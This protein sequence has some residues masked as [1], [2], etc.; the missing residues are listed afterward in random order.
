MGTTRDAIRNDSGVQLAFV[1]VIEGY[2]WLICDGDTSGAVTAW[3]GSQ[4]SQ[5][6]AGLEVSGGMAQKLE[7]WSNELPAGGMTFTIYGEDFAVDMFKAKPSIRSE[8]TVSFDT[9]NSVPG[10]NMT[11]KDAGLFS[12]SD[13]VTIGNE[14]FEVT[15]TPAGNTIAI[16]A[17]GSGVFYPFTGNVGADNTGPGAH[18]VPPNVLIGDY[19]TNS[20]VYVTD[21]PATWLG[22]KVGL[23]VHR[24]RDGV[25]DTKAQAEVWFAGLIDSIDTVGPLGTKLQCSGIQQ[26]IADSVIL[27]DQWSARALP[28]YVF[29]DG[30]YV[31]VRYYQDSGTTASNRS[32][33]FTAATPGTSADQFPSGRYTA[34]EFGA[35]LAKHLDDDGTIGNAGSSF[36]LRWSAYVFASDN[37]PRFELVATE[38]AAVLGKIEIVASD[39]A[40]LRFLGF[41]NIWAPTDA[42]TCRVVG[43]QSDYSQ[44]VRIRSENAPYRFPTFGLPGIGLSGGNA[45]DLDEADGTFVDHTSL[46]SPAAQEIVGAGE[47]WS[48]YSMGDEIVFLGRRVGDTQITDITMAT[49]LSK[50]S[51]G[52]GTA[53]QRALREGD[54]SA[55][56]VKQIFYACDSFASMICKLFAST[57]GQGTNHA[58][59]DVFPFGAGISWDLLGSSFEESLKA[60]EQSG[61]EDSLAIVVEKPTNLWDVIK[62]DFA[63]RMAAPV[64]KDGGLVVAQLNV[65][66]AST[67]DHAFNET[68]KSDTRDTV[69]ETVRDY[70]AH[71][72]KI[73]YNRNPVTDKYQDHFIVRDQAAYQSAG[74]SGT[75]KTI[76][77]RNSY[78]GVTASGASAQALGDM[79]ASRFLP[80]LARPLKRWTRSM[81]HNSFHAAPGDTCTISDDRI[82]DPSSG[83]IGVAAR[84]GTIMDTSYSLGI[85]S[86]GQTYHGSVGILFTEEDRLF[87]LAP[88]AEHATATGSGYTDGWD[89]S[90][91]SLLLN[92][93]SYSRSTAQT[94]AQS[95]SSGDAVRIT[96]L[97]PANPAAADSFVDT[98]ASAPGI[99]T[100]TISSVDYDELPLTNGFGAGGRPAFDST[101]TYIVNFDAYDQCGASQILKAFQADD[102]DGQILDT[103]EPNLVAD[104]LKPGTS[105]AADLTL[106]PSRYAAEQYGDGEPLSVSFVRD[107]CRMANNLTNYKTAPQSP[108]MGHSTVLPNPGSGLFIVTWTI[109]FYLGNERWP[110]GLVRKL[111]VAPMFYSGGG[112][113]SVRVTSSQ[114]PP[115]G[116]TYTTTSWFG[117]KK[118]ATFST[119]SGTLQVSTAQQLDVVRSQDM[120]HITWITVECE[121]GSAFRGLAELRLG[122]LE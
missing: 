24:I 98:I 58:D 38:G 67:A 29:N 71:T 16:A 99:G 64:W 17:N 97:D 23:Y 85:S 33:S 106:L 89:S 28:G 20:P 93:H 30:D 75:T 119:S 21:A 114:N 9:S 122:P 41:E 82:R 22:K 77:A 74:N 46:L 108:S 13:T 1:L 56:R 91:V 81:N 48:F 96:E 63:L 103:A 76:K 80:V 78:D 79:L 55:M 113:K 111:S 73:E 60:L 110:A 92:Q 39:A 10:F 120:P 115:K 52:D 61:V 37:G 53:G 3:S 2:P 45:M 116:D 27:Q 19:Q 47:T 101:K 70:L 100:V 104:E 65:P 18:H 105:V 117:P 69:T 14:T 43:A 11:V 42:A 25:W 59:Y 40:I 50:L 83:Q 84:A 72:I 57:D 62:S 6:R 4:W 90:G 15:G 31:W 8:L 32:A 49:P 102:A 118:Q 68:N 94:D 88:S 7:P 51:N 34:Q 66:N 87:P 5:A 12:A 54:A 121:D 107:Q 86:G 36:T 26:L 109:P 35:L 44:R 112:S 95:F